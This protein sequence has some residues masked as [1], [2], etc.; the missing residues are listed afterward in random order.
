MFDLGRN[1]LAHDATGRVELIEVVEEGFDG[2][3]LLV[4]Y[5]LAHGIF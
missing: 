5:R 3:E 1:G 2:C 4:V